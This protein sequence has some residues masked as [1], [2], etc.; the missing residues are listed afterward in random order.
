MVSPN[1]SAV[2]RI[3]SMARAAAASGD[4]NTPDVGRE[5]A[6]AYERLRLE[7]KGLADRAGWNDDD[8]FDRELPTIGAAP[9]LRQLPRAM[10]GQQGMVDALAAGQRARVMLGQLAAWAEGYQEAF[11][12]E[13][14]FRADAE[15]KLKAAQEKA[16][17]ATKGA[18]GFA[19][20]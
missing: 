6:A 4:A 10:V 3:K 18:V 8:S 7:A 17:A 1:L 20:T 19:A 9:A 15:A 14:R 5:L 2:L 12:L 16:Q 11:E 13:E